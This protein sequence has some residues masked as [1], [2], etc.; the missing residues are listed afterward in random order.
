M[1]SSDRGVNP[2][3]MTITKNIGRAGGS[4]QLFPVLNLCTL[5]TEL[6]KSDLAHIKYMH[7]KKKKHQYIWANANTWNH[8]ELV[9]QGITIL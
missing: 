8:T 9:N 4:N 5:P 2:V 7:Q 3:A 1:D 6:W